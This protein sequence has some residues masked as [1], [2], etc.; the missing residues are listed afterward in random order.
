MGQKWNRQC[1]EMASQPTPRI[2]KSSGFFTS[3]LH[4]NKPRTQ[5]SKNLLLSF[6]PFFFLIKYVS[7][8]SSPVLVYIPSPQ[9]HKM[10]T[11]SSELRLSSG[12]AL[13]PI[14]CNQEMEW[15]ALKFL[16][17]EDGRSNR[18]KLEL[19]LILFLFAV[20]KWY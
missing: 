7:V 4:S 5:L 1:D 18:R 12:W 17:C 2:Q 6:F 3:A 10:Y 13:S 11:L 8:Q 9:K 16:W 14:L 19:N 15:V 20:I